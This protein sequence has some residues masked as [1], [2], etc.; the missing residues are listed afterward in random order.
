M[1]L[2]SMFKAIWR[3]IIGDSSTK[4]LSPTSRSVY[5]AQQ[6]RQAGSVRHFEGGWMPMGWY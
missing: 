4:D 5:D 3:F 6:A 2:L 1:C